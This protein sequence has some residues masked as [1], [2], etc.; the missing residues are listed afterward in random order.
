MTS[1]TLPN[2]LFLLG[3]FALLIPTI[4]VE[5]PQAYWLFLLASSF[6]FDISKWLLLAGSQ[7]TTR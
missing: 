5:D 7:R 2:S 4:M 3:G 6:P 1:L